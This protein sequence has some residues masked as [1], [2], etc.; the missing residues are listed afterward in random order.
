M[1]NQATID[2][3]RHARL[4]G[5]KL[6]SYPGPAPK[7]MAEAF[8]I[9]SAVRGSI[10]W[11]LAGWKIGCTSERAQKA[12]HTDGPFPGP[13]YAE[14]LFA[15]GAYVET[16]SSNSRT[17][18][19]EIAFTMA[20]DLPKREQAWTVTEVL[21]AVATVH[22][23]IEIVN[24]RLPKGF[25]DVVEWYVADGGLNHALVLGAG[26]KPLAPGDYAKITN[27]VSI[28][29]KLR[30]TGLGTN[31]LGGPEL[32]LT[33]LANN[34]IEKGLFLRAGD[35]VTTGVITEVFDTKIGDYVEATYDH[36][37][38]VIVQL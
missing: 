37:G 19:P 5:E 14:R 16:L 24:P 18:E 7:D 1:T 3:L 27:S 36:L 32:A 33:W 11:T 22:P 8:A 9:Q 23:S 12:L 13:V 17:T 30:S 15:S 20:R 6:T 26:V 29:G 4:S 35:V 2:A 10:G 38:T 25:N 21:A 28:N 34:L 31:A